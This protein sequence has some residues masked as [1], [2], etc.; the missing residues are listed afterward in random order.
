MQNTICIIYSCLSILRIPRLTARN[1]ADGRILNQ[2]CWGI[3]IEFLIFISK[4]LQFECGKV[5]TFLVILLFFG[6]E[7]NFK[8]TFI[9]KYPRVLNAN[10]SSL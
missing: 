5:C 6:V 8:K 7:Q 9:I 1:I 4:L 2:F 3:F 10:H